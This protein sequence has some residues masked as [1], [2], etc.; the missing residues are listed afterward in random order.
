MCVNYR[1]RKDEA[2]AVVADIEADG[3]RALAVQA[4]VSIEADVGR[5]FETCDRELGTLSAL[6]NNAGV[7]E[8]QMRV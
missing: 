7:L 1:S 6:V 5:M 8:T 4:D 2:A 3:G